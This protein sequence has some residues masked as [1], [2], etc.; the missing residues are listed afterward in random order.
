MRRTGKHEGRDITV[1]AFFV[2]PGS[3]PAEG[4]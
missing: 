2:Q 4:S 3:C 1:A